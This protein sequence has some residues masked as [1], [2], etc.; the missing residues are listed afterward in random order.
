MRLLNMRETSEILGVK[1][2][3]LYMWRWRG[4]NLPFIKIGGSLRISEEDLY[5]FIQRS[6]SKKV[7]N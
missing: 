6:K 3:T 5:K 1:Q 7:K 4:V 2:K